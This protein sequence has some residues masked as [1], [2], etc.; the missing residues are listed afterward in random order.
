MA[1]P[2]HED[3]G[4]LALGDV[5][6]HGIGQQLPALARMA[7]GLALLHRQAGVEQQHAVLRPFDEAA[8]R[9]GEGREGHAQ[10]ALHLLEDVLQRRRHAHARRHRERQA[11]GLPPA[12][13]RVLAQD[14]H[15]HFLGRCQLQ[16]T[17]RL[18]RE[19]HRAGLQALVQEGQ[20]LLARGPGE[21]V[22]DQRLPSRRH[23]PVGRVGG[24]Q[25]VGLRRGN[26]VVLKGHGRSRALAPQRGPGPSSR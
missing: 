22:L 18:R 2:E 7:G 1:A 9:V 6:D 10:V 20:Q 26:S 17:Q 11:F 8:A 21:K 5:A 19:D 4:A 15:A 12:V 25:L 13:V 3:H 23:G 24:L 16:R 14:D